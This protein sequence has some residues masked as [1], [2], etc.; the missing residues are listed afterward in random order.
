M[1][2][3]GAAI[4]TPPAPD[5]PSRPGRLVG[6]LFPDT[7]R[8]VLTREGYV[9]RVWKY[10]E[11]VRSVLPIGR[12]LNSYEAFSDLAGE[13]IITP[14]DKKH[15]PTIPVTGA[16]VTIGVELGCAATPQSL[17]INGNLSNAVE[18][19][20]TPS[21]QGTGTVSGNGS[22]GSTGGQGGGSGS[23][24]ITPG[25]SATAADTVTTGGSLT[26]DIG[27]GMTRDFPIA[28]KPL[29]GRDGY[30]VARETRVSVDGCLGGAQIRS[31]A[32][33][34]ISTPLGENSITTYGRTLFIDRDHPGAPP[35]LKPAK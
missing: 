10:S 7:S 18:G 5:V 29:S 25:L 21:I 20:V 6:G 4:A 30:V 32:T 11:H 2:G 9:L 17:Q 13:A 3:S 34:A 15:P 1:L 27:P 26:G 16:A 8:A 28:T 31:Y 22:G 12:A 14:A 33:A 23:L 24:S 19:S 35:K